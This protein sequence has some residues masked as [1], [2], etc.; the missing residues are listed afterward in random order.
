MV[1]VARLAR[2]A[3]ASMPRA[4][5]ETMTKP[6][7]PRSRASRSANFRPAADALREPTIATIGRDKRRELAAHRD[8]RRRVVD[9]GKPRRIVRLRR[10]RRSARR[11]GAP[12]RSR[13]RPRR[14]DRSRMPAPRRRAARARA[15]RRA[16]RARCRNGRPARGTCAARHCR[17]GSAAASRAAPRRSSVRSRSLG[18]SAR[19]LADLAF[20][21]LQQPRDVGA[22]HD[23]DQDREQQEQPALRAARRA[24]RNRPAIAAQA[25][26]EASEE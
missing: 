24:T 22:M 11:A 3:A 19:L 5:P 7:S 9:R 26:S 1:P 6:A 18:A 13:A 20:G 10:A 14:A 4:S 8:Q 25:I 21:A 15:A 2:C 12:P 17:C 23:E 16:P